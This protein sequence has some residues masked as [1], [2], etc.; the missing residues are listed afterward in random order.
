ME[1]ELQLLAFQIACP[2][3]ERNK[4]V[5]RDEEVFSL[6]QVERVDHVADARVFVEKHVLLH[7]SLLGVQ[8]LILHRVH[9]L[10]QPI[11]EQVLENGTVDVL[12]G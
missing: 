3:L 9:R 12:L 5:P 11:F 7:S 8:Q 10:H 4:P 2:E 1:I 6:A